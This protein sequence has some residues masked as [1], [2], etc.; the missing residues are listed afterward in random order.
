[1]HDDLRRPCAMSRW[2][3]TEAE[4]ANAPGTANT[5]RASCAAWWAVLSVPDRAPA[6]TTTVTS[7][8]AAISRFQAREVKY[9]R[10]ARI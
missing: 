7:A 1:V 2:H 4:E 6:S 8:S 3:Q 9:M 5:G 10:P